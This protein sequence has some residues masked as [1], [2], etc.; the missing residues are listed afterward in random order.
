MSSHVTE[1][2]VDLIYEEVDAR[3]AARLHQHLAACEPCRSHYDALAKVHTL[4]AA[5]LQREE[6]PA[7]LQ[8]RLRAL[9][10]GGEQTR[11]PSPRRL[12]WALPVWGFAL[13]V[14]LLFGAAVWL[15]HDPSLPNDEIAK[16]PSTVK[17]HAHAAENTPAETQRLM[18]RGEAAADMGPAQT[19][20]TAHPLEEPF[21]ASTVDTPAPP[22]P[23][24]VEL[25]DFSAELAQR[26]AAGDQESVVAFASQ[27]L[28]AGDGERA[29]LLL[30]RARAY[31][32]LDRHLDALPDLREVID[33]FPAYAEREEALFLLALSLMA[34][35]SQEESRTLLENLI[36]T[37][38][39]YAT[40]AAEQLQSLDA[41]RSGRGALSGGSTAAARSQASGAKKART[42]KE[43]AR[44]ALGGS[45]KG[46]TFDF[47]ADDIAGQP[48]SAPA[49]TF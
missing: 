18:A 42:S 49:K 11:Q 29:H 1:Q 46:S 4:Y 17:V 31:Q 7:A 21:Q 30:Y 22:V 10:Q 2:L 16:A 36:A 12:P 23:A 15:F 40:A 27:H 48:Q 14:T 41:Q 9:A 3:E 28:D 43:A 33:E 19:L 32:G 20:A 25:K 37:E 45:G 47:E 26:A 34:V 24:A 13:G 44:P 6:A 8:A 38:S 5:H 35:G 39:R